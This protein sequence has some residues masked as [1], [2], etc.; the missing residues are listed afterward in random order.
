VSAAD[1]TGSSRMAAP[2]P[3]T[4]AQPSQTPPPAAASGATD[5]APPAV[6]RELR[7]R[8][9]GLQLTLQPTADGIPTAWVPEDD[10]RGVLAYLKTEAS[11]PFNALYDLGA[12]DER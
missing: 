12:I 11:K 3:Q 9:P 10:L 1:G 7:E 5:A 6:V 2:R 4:P 8:F